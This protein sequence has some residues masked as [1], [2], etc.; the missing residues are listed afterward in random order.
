ML[1]VEMKNLHEEA[2]EAAEFLRSRMKG[3][4]EARGSQLRLQEARARDVKLLLHKFLH[5]KGLDSYRVEVVHPGLVEVFGPEHVRP[6][7][8][9]TVHGSP[10]SPGATMPYAFPFS[11]SLPGGPV[12]KTRAKK[13][14]RKRNQ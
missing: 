6:Y 11:P 13:L 8:T 14:K 9:S 1:T 5:H 2:G 12:K 10:P 3:P 4:V 7:G